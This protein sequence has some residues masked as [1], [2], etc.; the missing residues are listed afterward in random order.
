VHQPQLFLHTRSV[1]DLQAQVF[2]LPD[3]R[4]ASL[5]N[6]K[7]LSASVS[8]LLLPDVRSESDRADSR[9][10]SGSAQCIGKP[11]NFSLL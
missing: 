1:P 11:V 8:P 6:V 2:Q 7:E 4:Q 5:L 10:A 9:L 3:I